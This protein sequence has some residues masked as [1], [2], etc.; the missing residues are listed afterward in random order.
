MASPLTPADPILSEYA[1]NVGYRRAVTNSEAIEANKRR[2]AM[3]MEGLVR[4]EEELDMELPRRR[5]QI[6]RKRE[7][8]LLAEE[9][10]V[11]LDGL[12]R[13]QRLSA[14]HGR[15][16][17]ERFRDGEEK[18][19]EQLDGYSS[20]ERRRLA[21]EATDEIAP[22]IQQVPTKVHVSKAMR[23]QSRK[24]ARSFGGKASE[25]RTTAVPT[26]S[27]RHTTVTAIRRAA[28]VS[29]TRRGGRDDDEPSDSSSS[30]ESD[31]DSDDDDYGRGRDEHAVSDDEDERSQ[32]GDVQVRGHSQTRHSRAEEV[33]NEHRSRLIHTPPKF[34]LVEYDGKGGTK[35]LS[36]W[37]FQ[38]ERQLA[39]QRL[40]PQFVSHFDDIEQMALSKV[41][42]SV[43]KWY[44]GE[45][46]RRDR[47]QQPRAALDSW[48]KFKYVLK[49]QYNSI[50]ESEL[51][52]EEWYGTA[53]EVRTGEDVMTFMSRMIDFRERLPEKKIP[54]I[55][56]LGRVERS[57]H[58]GFPE[59]Y[60]RLCKWLK[61]EAR[62]GTP[63][64][65]IVREKMTEIK[66]DI[67]VKSAQSNAPTKVSTNKTAKVNAI[68]T[69]TSGEASELA[70]YKLRAHTAESALGEERKANGTKVRR[71]RRGKPEV[72]NALRSTGGTES[73][74]STTGAA[75]TAAGRFPYTEVQIK[76]LMARG[77]C[78]NC[79]EIGHI[80]RYCTNKMVELSATLGG[81]GAPTS[82]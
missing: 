71:G 3:E 41:S 47:S 38:L 13:Q 66:R 53:M 2:R 8:L 52:L 23:R 15:R 35:A 17:R 12:A 19:E 37:L 24:D 57:V 58:A 33:A 29:A 40:F 7:E 26:P 6:E 27:P 39:N 81:A 75:M 22:L 54:P 16:E 43:Y 63:D 46:K 36:S 48:S 70:A 60:Y 11:A 79:G 73:A 55:T 67:G 42:Q 68:A 30:D 69:A 21:T 78:F 28:P 18:E 77:R 76:E 82:N 50:H 80:S 31:D 64:L 59:I 61:A 1:V 72:L 20:A 65:H 25:Y 45:A 56:F 49:K 4:E 62:D 74:A 14:G 9:D 5:A 51:A 34:D 32:I 10:E 44:M